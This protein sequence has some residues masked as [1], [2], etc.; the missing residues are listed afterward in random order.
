LNIGKSMVDAK[1]LVVDDEERICRMV[2]ALLSREGFAA[3]FTTLAAEVPALVRR[4]E[5]DLVMLDLIMPDGD[6]YL[7]IRELRAH[8][9]C[10]IIVVTGKGDTVDKVVGLEIGADDYVTKPFDQ[11]EL[12]ARVRSVLRRRAETRARPDRVRTTVHFNGWEFHVAGGVLKSPQGREVRLTSHEMKLLG[13]MVTTPNRVITREEVSRVLTG[14][15]WNPYDRSID[16]LV[17]KLRRKLEDKGRTPDLI[18]TVRGS[19]YKFVAP[20]EQR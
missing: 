6:G 1:V 15:G 13:L 20:V 17:A 19:G 3:E 18:L 4:I 2:C 12:I 14:R 9:D 10:S 8:F 11:R 5:P 7:L 16:V